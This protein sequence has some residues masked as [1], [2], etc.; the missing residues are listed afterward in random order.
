[1]QVEMHLAAAQTWFSPFNM[2]GPAW[3]QVLSANLFKLVGFFLK[4]TVSDYLYIKQVTK[5]T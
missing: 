4:K 2:K 1:M 5:T 3:A